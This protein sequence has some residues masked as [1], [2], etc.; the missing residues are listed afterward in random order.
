MKTKQRKG[1][2]LSAVN[3]KKFVK[4]LSM[5]DHGCSYCVSDLLKQFRS[6]FPQFKD[7]VSQKLKVINDERKEIERG[8]YKTKK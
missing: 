7:L 8:F 5:A 4:I 6:E 3:A 1:Q 2:D